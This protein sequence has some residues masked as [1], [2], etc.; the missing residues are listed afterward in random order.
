MLVGQKRTSEL[1]QDAAAAASRPARRLDYTDLTHDYRK[2]MARV[3]VARA[4]Q[5]LSEL[6]KLSPGNGRDA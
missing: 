6:S 2:K 4:Q 3:Y 5:E 1:I